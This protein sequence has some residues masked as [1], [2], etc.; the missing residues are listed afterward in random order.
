MGSYS[1]RVRIN[2]HTRVAFHGL[3]MLLR[4]SVC[5]GGLIIL[6]HYIDHRTR[7][8]NVNQCFNLPRDL[9]HLLKSNIVDRVFQNSKLARIELSHLLVGFIV[10]RFNDR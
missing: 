2:F 5:A 9:Q 7:R 3:R 1:M 6:T 8:W 10:S 4:D